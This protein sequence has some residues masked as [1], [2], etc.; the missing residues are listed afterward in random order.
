[1]LTEIDRILL[2]TPDVVGSAMP[3]RDLLGAEFVSRDRLASLAAQR[4]TLRVGTT[5][6]EFLEPDGEGVIADEL[7]RRGRAHLFAAG[8]GSPDAAGVARHAAGQGA[9]CQEADGRSYVTLE[10]ENAPIRFVVS[11]QEEREA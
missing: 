2:A 6:I 5:D 7:R 8:A 11:P 3:W 9:I 1:M 10:I 4:M